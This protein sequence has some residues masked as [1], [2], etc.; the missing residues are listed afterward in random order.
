MGQ[1][2]NTYKAAINLS[3]SK[4][5]QCIFID[6]RY[7]NAETVA[8]LGISAFHIKIIKLPKKN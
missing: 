5:E 2:E 7:F 6:D 4:P 3:F 1:D 8:N